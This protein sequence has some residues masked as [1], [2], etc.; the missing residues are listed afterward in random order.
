MS[1][2]DVFGRVTPVSAQQAD[3]VLVAA[4]VIKI[5]PADELSHAYPVTTQ[6]GMSTYT[7]VDI[8]AP[9]EYR[10]VRLYW[11]NISAAVGRKLYVAANAENWVRG[12]MQGQDVNRRVA[13]L[14]FGDHIM[15]YSP[16]PITGLTFSSDGSISVNTHS[17]LIVWGR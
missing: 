1:G 7:A 9:G 6:D 14:A 16:V 13:E 12:L 10:K 2:L 3:R 5:S 11:R 8:A 15:L 17:I 4:G